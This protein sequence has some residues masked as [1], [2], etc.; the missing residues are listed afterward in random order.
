MSQLTNFPICPGQWWR[1]SLSHSL[2]IRRSRTLRCQTWL[3]N[4]PTKQ[5]CLCVFNGKIWENLRTKWR[6]SFFSNARCG[7]RPWFYVYHLFHVLFGHQKWSDQ[8][9]CCQLEG[10]PKWNPKP[11]RTFP[12]NTWSPMMV[13]GTTVQPQGKGTISGLWSLKF[14]RYPTNKQQLL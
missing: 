5:S 3:E 1:N 10:I 8:K 4:I 12:T 2:P 11:S 6:L 14:V 7:I 13:S 9:W